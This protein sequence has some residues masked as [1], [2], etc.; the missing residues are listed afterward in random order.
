MPICRKLQ[1]HSLDACTVVVAHDALVLFAQDVLQTAT[2][3]GHE[4]RPRFQRRHGKLGVEG[5]KVALLYVAIGGLHV[6]DARQRQFLRQAP[7]MRAK[8]SL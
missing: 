3:P 8:G 7:L 5:G 6:G 1:A 4:G 2:D